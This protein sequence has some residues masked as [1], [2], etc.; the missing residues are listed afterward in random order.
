M[1]I[2]KSIPVKT[3]ILFVV[4]IVL[5]SCKARPESDLAGISLIP[6]PVAVKGTGDYFVL[7][8]TTV[9]C[10]Q[11][12]LPA[13]ENIARYLG[14]RLKPATG[15][16]FELVESQ[17]AQKFSIYLTLT[18]TADST[19][20]GYDLEIT[21][22]LLRLSAKTPIGL[23]RGVQTIMQLLPPSIEEIVRQEGPW[24]IATGVIND[25]P[26]YPYRGV[27]LDVARHFFSVEDVKKVI[28]QIS[29]YKINVLHLHLSDDQ[30][31][32]IEV[33]SW[34]KLTETG[35]STEVGGG[36]GGF[37]TQE[38]FS[39]IVK[40][41]AD[42]FIMIVPEIEMP[43]HCNAA[44]ASYPELNCNNKAPQLYTETEVGFSSLCTKKE[45]TYK[46]IDDVVREISAISPGAFFHIG[47]DEAQSTKMQDYVPFI[48]RVQDIVTSH[49]KEVIGWDEIANSELR[50][51]TVV[52]FWSNAKN[53]QLAT[54]QGAKIIMSPSKKTYLDMQY[55]EN[56]KPGVHW[57]AY[58]DVDSAYMWYPD[59]YAP[60]I[61]NDNILGIEAPLWT[62]TV[63]SLDEIEFMLFPKLPGYAEIGWT[64]PALRNWDDYRRRLADHG[65]RFKALGIDFY[66]SDKV[67]WKKTGE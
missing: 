30:G 64:L 35:G 7:K 40:Y 52:Q 11:G 37:Y 62:E 15:F 39:D 44:L 41:A 29:Y 60:G 55:N 16:N 50:P 67:N 49:G 59:S 22:D 61:T 3:L 20:E 21:R 57:A 54:D 10:Y 36:E 65:D 13:V 9:I 28:D 47:G 66:E 12:G 4:P 5:F 24:D 38:Q 56:T 6:K 33:K 1:R 46:F 43:S 27:M 8:P 14:E 34:P 26:E 53:S 63:T 23:F 25:E 18:G 48:N 58:I 51:T 19:Y 32:R 2:R 45:I 31:W 17:D 42:R